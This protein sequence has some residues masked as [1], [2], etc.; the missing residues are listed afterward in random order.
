MRIWVVIA[1]ASTVAD[2]RK[3]G[4]HHGGS[5]RPAMATFFTIGHSTRSLPELIGL[6]QE[7]QVRLLVDVRTLP[8]SRTNPQFN[9][10]SL[11]QALAAAGIDYEHLATL[12]GLR[13]RRRDAP[14]S[15]NDFWENTSFRNFADYAATEPFRQGLKHL[16]EL[17]YERCCAVMCSEA[18]WWR[19]HRRIIADYLLAAGETVYHLMGSRRAEPAKLTRAA[20]AAPDGTLIYRRAAGAPGGQ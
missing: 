15:V 17:G 8:R 7:A 9:I 1:G 16:R 4:A 12:G 5:V 6:L 2:W 20:Q 10:D 14:P 19:C 13:G 11:P 18:V 3:I